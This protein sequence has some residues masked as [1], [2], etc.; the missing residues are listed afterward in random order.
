VSPRSEHRLDR[1]RAE[2]EDGTAVVE[3]LGVAVVLLVPVVYLVLVLA[4]LQAA[5]FAV[6]GA[7]REASRVL[8]TAPDDVVAGRTLAAV[9]LAFSDQG[10]DPSA[11]AGAVQVT[12]EVDC[13]APGTTIT[14]EVST[15]VPLPLVPGFLRASVPAEIPV[16]ATVTAPVDDFRA[17]PAGAA[18]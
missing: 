15:T 3:F 18:P 4:Q 14:V 9:G 12:C 13:R 11:A 1:L 16:A 10:L 17:R 7:A 8:V 5:L 2:P 6:E